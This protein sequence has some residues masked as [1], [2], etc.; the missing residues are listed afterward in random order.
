MTFLVPGCGDNGGVDTTQCQAAAA[1]SL[2]ACVKA[3]NDA[4]RACYTNDNQACADDDAA[5]VAALDALQT[6]VQGACGGD[7]GVVDSGFGANRTLAGL[8]SKLRVSCTSEAES[9]SAR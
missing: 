4:T 9:L 7:Q 6:S 5:V 8:A 1:T 3:L 2:G